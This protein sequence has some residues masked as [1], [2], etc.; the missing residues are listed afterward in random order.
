MTLPPE[1]VYIFGISQRE[2]TND[3]LRQCGFVS[4]PP[5]G[6]LPLPYSENA[7]GDLQTAIYR[8]DSF[9]KL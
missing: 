6:A 4:K 1:N 8:T 3:C 5:G 9:R 7:M 2:I